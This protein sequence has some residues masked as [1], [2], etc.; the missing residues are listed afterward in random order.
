MP[1]LLPYSQSKVQAHCC[2][3]TPATHRA[4]A[5]MF[6]QLMNLSND[7]TKLQNML[8]SVPDTIKNEMVKNDNK[9][10][11]KEQNISHDLMF[12]AQLKDVYKNLQNAQSQ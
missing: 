7:P 3:F 10:R 1:N 5:E 9:I 4:G 2:N 6:G 11:N 8:H 12:L